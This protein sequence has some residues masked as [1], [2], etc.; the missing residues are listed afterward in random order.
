MNESS[1]SGNVIG[2]FSFDVIDETHIVAYIW[3]GEKE[4]VSCSVCGWMLRNIALPLEL[5]FTPLH[6][7]LH[8]HPS[9]A[10]WTH[11]FST[12]TLL[13][14]NMLLGHPYL[15]TQ[16]CGLFVVL[17]LVQFASSTSG[18]CRVIFGSAGVDYFLF[19]SHC[20]AVAFDERLD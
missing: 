9:P 5:H 10:R 13:S 17:M 3:G 16:T 1:L 7:P 8:P 14:V 4:S 20:C 19:Y 11:V 18:I 2:F 15:K 6:P 12:N